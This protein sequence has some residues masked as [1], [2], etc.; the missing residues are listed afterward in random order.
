MP[1]KFA[2]HRLRV[3]LSATQ[4]VIVATLVNIALYHVPL[5]DF[6]SSHIDSGSASGWLIFLIVFTSLFLVTATALFAL[7]LASTKLV[8]FFVMV[9]FVG[10]AIAL[11]FVASYQVILDRSMMGNVFNTDMREAADLFHPMLLLYVALLGVLP[12]WLVSRVDIVR[13]RRIRLLA[14]A[15]AVFLACVAIM[16]LNAGRWAWLDEH[17]KSVGGMAMPWSY[18]VNAWRYRLKQAR[19]SARQRLLPDAVF[20]SND[21]MIVVMVIGESARAENFSL[22]G[23]ARKTNPLLERDSVT[24]LGP[25]ESAA[26]YTTASVHSMLSARGSDS[27]DFEPL[28]SYLHRQGVDVIWR[29]DNWGEPRVD[30]DTYQRDGELR[31]LCKGEGCAHDEVLLTGL[32]QRIAASTHNKI[33]VVLHTSGSHGPAYDR[34]YPKAFEH[35]KPVCHSVDLKSCTHQS[36]VNAYDN[37]ILYTDHFLHRVIELLKRFGDVPSMM[38]YLS[39]HGESLGEHGLYLHGAPY[40]LAPDQQKR[41]PFIVWTSDAFEKHHGGPAS[42]KGRATYGYRNIF[43]TVMGAFDMRSAIYDRKLDLFGRMQTAAPELASN[44]AVSRH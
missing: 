2:V 10:N 22:Y 36:L 29:T 35:F 7:M 8:K 26:T 25:A 28:P 23:Y 30:V 11:Y 1:R 42:A 13:V 21:R 18:G 41:V 31:K 38:I 9:M 15:I 4:F 44:G 27:D 12:A 6:V 5:F 3:S 24:V 39:D 20:L 16:Y 43:H 32:E 17:S 19:K 33:F 37:S 14:H 40:A 34:K